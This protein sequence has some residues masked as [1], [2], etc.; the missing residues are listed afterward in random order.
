MIVEIIGGIS[1]LAIGGILTY[2][3]KNRQIPDID[4]PIIDNRKIYFGY[5]GRIENQVAET[6]DHTNLL[7]E[8]QFEG[9]EKASEAILAAKMDTLL[10]VHVQL[11]NNSTKDTKFTLHADCANNLRNLFNY[12]R[13][14]GAL[15]Y[16]K[17]LYPVD[18][19][20]TMMESPTDLLQGIRTLKVVAGEF[21][22]LKNV[23]YAVIYAAKP[24]SYTCHE[25]YDYIGVNDYQFKSQ[26]FI[27]GT[28]DSIKKLGKQ[29]FI[30][31][32]GAFGQDPQPF[33]NF[34][35]ANPEVAAIIPF[36]W[37]GP[38]VPADKWIGI[39]DQGIRRQAYIDIGKQLK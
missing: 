24:E 23:K 14:T 27:N 16:V 19:P 12:L 20:N 13:S 18:E 11:F 34:A 28:Y 9:H 26:I 17:V 37:F 8:S 1:I 25:E 7:W 31:P 21:E 6:R 38:Q 10:D 22:E 4:L 30:V 3:Y 2:A 29:T 5:Y 32:G 36:V 35:N 33:L 15:K 39:R